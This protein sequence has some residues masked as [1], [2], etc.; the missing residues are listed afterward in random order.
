MAEGFAKNKIADQHNLQQ[1]YEDITTRNLESVPSVDLYIA[2]FPCQPFS[3]AGKQQGFKD[4]KGRGT[5][6]NNIFNESS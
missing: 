2:G 4:A 5:I 3:T 6:I 1:F